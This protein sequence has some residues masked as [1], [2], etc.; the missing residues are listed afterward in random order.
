MHLQLEHNPGPRKSPGYGRVDGGGAEAAPVDLG[1]LVVV[2]NVGDRID[3]PVDSACSTVA[4]DKSRSVL[5]RVSEKRSSVKVRFKLWSD[6][7]SALEDTIW[8]GRMRMRPWYSSG[9]VAP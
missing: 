2:G 6:I 3:A 4:I 1:G 8:R 7:L 9:P 5:L